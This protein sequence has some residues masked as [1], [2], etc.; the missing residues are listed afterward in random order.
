MVWHISRGKHTDNTFDLKNTQ[1]SVRE[2]KH[3]CITTVTKYCTE[4]CPP[5]VLSAL[6]GVFTQY[7]TLHFNSPIPNLSPVV[8]FLSR[9]VNTS[10]SHY[11]R[12]LS[13]KGLPGSG[14]ILIY[15]RV[16]YCSENPQTER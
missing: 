5:S 11:Q 7:K 3:A 12:T 14:N 10:L 1:E 9:N 2:C 16:L 13:L 8:Y 4:C 15:W 6:C